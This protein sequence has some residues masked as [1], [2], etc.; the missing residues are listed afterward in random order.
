VCS[1]GGETEEMP[2]LPRTRSSGAGSLFGSAGA[3]SATLLRSQVR[4]HRAV[5]ADRFPCRNCREGLTVSTV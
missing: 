1:G 5:D 3:G 2:L 4:S